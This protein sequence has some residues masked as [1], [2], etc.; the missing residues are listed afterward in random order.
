MTVQ[1]PIDVPCYVFKYLAKEYGTGPFNLSDVRLKELKDALLYGEI[2]ASVVAPALDIPSASYLIY[3]E[4]DRY[5]SVA[6]ALR[7][8]GGGMKRE[9][10]FVHEFWSAAINYCNGLMDG[11]GVNRMVALERFLEKYEID[12]ELYSLDSAYRVFQRWLKKRRDCGD[13]VRNQEHRQHLAQRRYTRRTMKRRA[14]KVHQ[15]QLE[16]QYGTQLDLFPKSVIH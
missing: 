1:V 2:H 11:S 7:S 12:E 5:S 4:F 9:S 3:L 13:P 14:T 8:R 6:R 15:Q 10:F 16:K